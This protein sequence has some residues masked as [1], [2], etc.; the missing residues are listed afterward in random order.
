VS[1]FTLLGIVSWFSPRIRRCGVEINSIYI[2]INMDD[3]Q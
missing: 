2:M 3:D 1:I